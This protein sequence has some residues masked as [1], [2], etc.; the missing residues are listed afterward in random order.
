MMR[1]FFEP[2]DGSY[3]TWYESKVKE[4]FYDV[5]VINDDHIRAKIDI[6]DKDK[7]VFTSI[8]YDKG[9]KVYVNGQRISTEKVQL[10]F[11]GFQLTPGSY[12]VEFKYEIPFL[13]IGALIS[14]ISSILLIIL[15][16][17]KP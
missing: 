15:T 14:M 9:W 7:Y 11:I 12:L 6:S 13:K 8:P 2:D 3:Q 5:N 10:G 17:R 4:S 16:R 1:V